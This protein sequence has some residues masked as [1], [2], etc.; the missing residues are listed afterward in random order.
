MNPSESPAERPSDRMA[1]QEAAP[2]RLVITTAAGIEPLLVEELGEL[3]LAAHKTPSGAVVVAGEWPE[4]A[5]VLTRSRLASRVLKSLREFSARH[6]KMLYDQ[7]RRIDWPALFPPSKSIAVQAFGATT[8]ADFTLQLAALKIKDAICDEFRAAGL[9]RPDVDR[10][11]PDVR[12]VAFLFNGRCELSLDLAGEP[13]HRR[14]YREEGAQAPLREN[15]AAALLRFA[16]YDG[17]AP[18]LDPFCGSGTIVIEAAL[19]A[20][21]IAPGLLRPVD[22]FAAATLF[23]AGRVALLAERAR[24]AAEKLT[25]PPHPVR[26]SDIEFEA[27][28]VARRNAAKAGVAESVE[29]LKQDACAIEAPGGWIVSNP[30]HGERLS[31]PETVATLL[32]EFVHR[33][34]HHGTGTKLALLLPRGPLENAVG[35]KPSRRLAVESGPL[36]LRFLSYEVYAGSR[37]RRA[38][39]EG[40]GPAPDDA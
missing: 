18:L 32:S 13:L 21:R 28:A 39:P 12:L 15:R 17:G 19:I 16:G 6:Q 9:P 4:A 11:D 10:Q 31:D 38:A 40:A 34:K 33:V 26:G 3:G 22:G 36:G 35:L 8:G 27:L 5:R 14:G 7:V 37:K 20:R 29:F 24:A 23:P 2:A 25:A 30:P 1:S